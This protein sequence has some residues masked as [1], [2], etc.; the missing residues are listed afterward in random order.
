MMRTAYI[1]I[2]QVD[3]LHLSVHH[4]RLLLMLPLESLQTCRAIVSSEGTGVQNLTSFSDKFLFATE[5]K[6]ADDIAV[7]MISGH[8]L[9]DACTDEQQRDVR[10]AISSVGTA[11]H[12]SIPPQRPSHRAPCWS[13]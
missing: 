3:A 5:Y 9:L 11:A 2:P 10:S 8:L 1:C 7:D 4:R 6:R 12:L 13:T